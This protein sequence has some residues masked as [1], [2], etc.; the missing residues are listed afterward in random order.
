MV[1]LI[2]LKGSWGKDTSQV[3]LGSATELW[4]RHRNSHMSVNGLVLPE[5]K[6]HEQKCLFVII[7]ILLK[8]NLKIRIFYEELPTLSSIQC[9]PQAEGIIPKNSLRKVL[10]GS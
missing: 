10:H 8:K 2:V 3:Q 9:F 7:Y 5:N 4:V 1:L 6:L